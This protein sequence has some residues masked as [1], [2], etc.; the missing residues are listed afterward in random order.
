MVMLELSSHILEIPDGR[1]T[2]ILL[3]QTLIGCA[4]LYTLSCS[5]SFSPYLSLLEFGEALNLQYESNITVWKYVHCHQGFYQDV[6]S[7]MC[8][9]NIFYLLLSSDKILILDPLL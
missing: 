3:R 9:R 6:V 8:V 1:P 5:I 4:Q 2:L 7:A